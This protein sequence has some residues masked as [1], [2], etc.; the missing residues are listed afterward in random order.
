MTPL[1]PIKLFRL[2]PTELVHVEGSGEE[3]D[4]FYF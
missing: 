1:V 3:E 2:K 4:N